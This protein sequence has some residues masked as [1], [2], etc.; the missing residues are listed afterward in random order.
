MTDRGLPRGCSRVSPTVYRR[1]G[2]KHTTVVI[3]ESF[4]QQI[5]ISEEP[6]L[7]WPG[8]NCVIRN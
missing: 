3:E 1:R 8:T 7:K 6:K 4:D 2:S 5:R